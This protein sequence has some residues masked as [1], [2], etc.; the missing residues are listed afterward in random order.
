MIR[1]ENIEDTL[2]F[3]VT[4]AIEDK[5]CSDIIA[6]I[7]SAAE[8]GIKNVVAHINSLGGSVAGV[9]GI[10]SKIKEHKLYFTAINEGFAFSAGA[11]LLASADV[12]KA[13]AY[14]TS[15]IHDPLAQGVT[16][17]DA[18][19][20]T[21][22]L[23]NKVKDGILSIFS[24]RIKNIELD[25][26]KILLEDETSWNAS[27][28][29]KNGLVDEI[30][31][32]NTTPILDNLLQ[33]TD[34]K[35]IYN[36]I[37]QF[38]TDN[39]LNKIINKTMTQEEIDNLIADKQ[40]LENKIKELEDQ[41]ANM[42]EKEKPEVEDVVE[43]PEEEKPEVEDTIETPEEEK[44]EEVDETLKNE[45]IDLKVEN[46]ILKNDLSDKANMISNAVT[47]HGV[48]VLN[49]ISYFIKNDS[50]ELQNKVD[51]LQATIT[52]IVNETNDSLDGIVN[53][54]GSIDYETMAENVFGMDSDGT[55]RLRLKTENIELHNK[56]F[57]IYYDITE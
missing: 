4:Q 45:L 38:N 24:N 7:Q 43:T 47:L 20:S 17:K 36:I 28:Q 52:N 19:G 49:T 16:L 41:L 37:N 42:V 18:K 44:P 8:S 46:F 1:I 54:S 34:H 6:Q 27:D 55:E 51:E 33:D 5:D 57:N 26:L 30:I 31:Y 32:T 2:H 13:Y 10:I 9:W 23:L 35:I 11:I 53:N 21:K 48:D 14:S 25:D 3:Y 22:R 50:V 56:L 12:A 39:D 15:M 40:A 29:L